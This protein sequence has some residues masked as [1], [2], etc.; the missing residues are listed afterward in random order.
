MDKIAHEVRAQEWISIIQAWRSSGLTKKQ[1]CEENGVSL[2]QFFYWQKNIREELYTEMKKKE[3]G[4]VPVAPA[5]STALAPAFA[6]IK[7]TSVAERQDRQF[8]PDAVIKV[9]DISIQL[10][11]TA[12]RELLE[13]IGGTLLHH[14]V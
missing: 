12:S 14:A 2:R 7:V 3:T 8:Q 9:G 4:V 6:E 13:R 5:E 1:W 10:T 11:N